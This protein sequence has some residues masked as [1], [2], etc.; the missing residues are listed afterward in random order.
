M[1]TCKNYKTDGGN[2]WVIGGKLV[3]E[4]GAVSEGIV[5]VAEE[6]EAIA[7]PASATAEVCATKINAI[8]SALQ[9]AGL[10]ETSE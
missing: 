5:P 6:V 10:M 3:L 2:T 7:T 9:S 1:N 4:D 8:I